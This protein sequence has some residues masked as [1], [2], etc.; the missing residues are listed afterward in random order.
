L[1]LLLLVLVSGSSYQ[2]ASTICWKTIINN[3]TAAADISRDISQLNQVLM[4]ETT[5]SIPITMLP[6]CYSGTDF[7]VAT[8]AAKDNK[9]FSG[10]EATFQ[11]LLTTALSQIDGALVT[12]QQQRR[13]NTRVWFRL[14]GCN[15]REVGFC[16][17]FVDIHSWDKIGYST[18][19]NMSDEEGISLLLV[20]PGDEMKQTVSS[21][22][23]DPKELINS[24][25]SDHYRGSLN[26]S[27]LVPNNIEGYFFFVGKFL[28]W[29]PTGKQAESIVLTN[30]VPPGHAIIFMQTDEL[31]YRVRELETFTYFVTSVSCH[32][33]LI[34]FIC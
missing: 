1:L 13:E 31:S 19:D 5:G 20:P 26:I 22:W 27:A 3:T 17:P 7:S 30:L 11:F 9:L 14:L 4:D 2:P 21:G 10:E 25:D 32:C 16:N 34:S 8:P 29:H 18:I 15:A 28:I 33:H 12:Q 6:S 23:L 24:D